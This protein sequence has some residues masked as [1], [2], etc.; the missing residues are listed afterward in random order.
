MNWMKIE[1][2]SGR[3]L[4]WVLCTGFALLVLLLL[5]SGFVAIQSMRYI[6]SDAG[7]LVAEEQATIRLINE[8]QG[9]EGNLSRVFYELATGRVSAD[10]ASLLRRIDS[11]E[12]ALH[13][14]AREGMASAD[15]TLWDRVRGA[16]NE[17]IDESRA[18]IRS[19]K[20]PS[21]ALYRKHQILLDALADLASTSVTSKG[22]A[23]KE[24][25]ERASRRIRSSVIL[26]AIGLTVA[27]VG[28]AFT[29]LAVM[30]MFQRLSWQAA[31]LSRLS[32][33]AMSDQE[34]T[35]R[36]LSHEM[37]DHFGQTLSAIE[38][39]LVAMKH[40]REF[41]AVRM[42]D[43]LALLK[44][45]VGNIREVSQLLRPSILDDFGLDASLQWL[46]NGFAERTGLTARYT[47]SFH[48]R[49]SD[50]QE[51][52]LFRIAQEALTNIARHSQA[53]KVHVE[54]AAER[55][56][57]RLSINDNGKGLDPAY[58]GVG[59]GLTGM[60]ARARAANGLLRME[61]QP[62]AGLAITVEVPLEQPAYV[63]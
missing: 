2:E 53:T 43:C 42:E 23:Q 44:E 57:V 28:A 35:A 18:V 39:N 54:L 10:P 47:S 9:E 40:M 50:Q 41:D 58:T 26:L 25:S 19:G 12:D 27:I 46:V 45:A 49:L 16:G 4:L 7:R 62:G 11:L 15:P 30:R 21:N 36:R 3:Y 63:T 31:E 24:Q 56:R 22:D 6:E 55:S 48:E 29:A 17:F 37:H 60:R 51:T 33:R 61:S 5:A 52:Q 38:A 34:E 1:H 8:V 13:Q 20:P 59:L 14:T 32:S